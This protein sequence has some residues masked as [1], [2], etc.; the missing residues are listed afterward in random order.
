MKHEHPRK[1]PLEEIMKTCENTGTYRSNLS[2]FP[3]YICSFEIMCSQYETFTKFCKHAKKN[4]EFGESKF[5]IECTYE[6]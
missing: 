1:K 5:V 2:Q 4:E 6:K 3:F